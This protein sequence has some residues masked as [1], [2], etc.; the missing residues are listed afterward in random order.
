MSQSEAPKDL[1]EMEYRFMGKSGLQISAISLGGW[2]TYGGHVGDDN[3]FACLKAAFDAGINFFDCAEGYAKGESEK[4]MGRAIKHFKWNRNDIVV[5]TK[6]YWGTH[7]SALPSPRNKI[8][9]LGLSR[10]HLIEA[11][12]ASLERLQLSY[13]DI[14]YAHRPD[15][16]T[17]IEETVRAFNYLINTGKTF[18]WGTSEWLAS[19]I[20]EA[21]A[22]A[23]RLGLIGPIVEQPGYS[24]LRPQKV[25]QEFKDAG[26]YTRRG[27]GLTIFSPLQGGLLT[28]KYVDGVP[29]DSRLRVSD[30]P[31]IQSV[32]K[33]VGSDAWNEQQ[34]KIK[35]LMDVAK[36]LGTDV[37]TLSMAWVL[38]NKN[39]SSA[40]TGASRPEQIYQTVKAV[41][42][43]RKL[44]KE[45][46][47]EIEQVMGSK[48]E[49]LTMRFG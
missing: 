14:L 12:E 29:E 19:E 35:K 26:L 22:V 1:P 23:D 28:G 21:W 37:A 30:D 4:V 7:N 49:A 33:G 42:V 38:S 41:D 25:D 16:Y 40:I 20:E 9:N 18:Y 10:K 11:T 6:I 43:Y 34:G 13:V 27:L 48:P 39:V 47:E 45:N 17:P 2:L 15:R 32:M 36:K 31:Y 5:S 44:T 8:N 46:L 24:L 3:T